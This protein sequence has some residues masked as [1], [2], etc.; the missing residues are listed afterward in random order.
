[1]ITPGS[2]L[3]PIFLD[4]EVNGVVL[5]EITALLSMRF[6]GY[7]VRVRPGGICH[8]IMETGKT[9]IAGFAVGVTKDYGKGFLSK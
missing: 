7:Y 3:S 5:P 9:P 4:N 8:R 6:S 1:M 2:F